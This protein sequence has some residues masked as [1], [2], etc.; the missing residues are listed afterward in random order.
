MVGE[1]HQGGLGASAVDWELYSVG[2]NGGQLVLSANVTGLP[3]GMPYKF[4]QIIPWVNPVPEADASVMAVLGLPMLL[5]PD[6]ILGVFLHE[7]LTLDIARGPLRLVGATIGVTSSG[8]S[9]TTARP[10][11]SCLASPGGRRSTVPSSRMAPLASPFG[12]R[13][14]NC[15]LPLTRPGAA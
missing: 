14:T 13:S 7:P 10:G 3:S 6:I 11:A 5:F 4:T 12:P 2:H 9:A 1:G 15:T 8:P